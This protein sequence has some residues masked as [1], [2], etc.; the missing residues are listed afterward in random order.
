MSWLYSIVFAGLLMSSGNDASVSKNEF[1]IDNPVTV[2]SGDETEKF[3]QTYPL[4]ANGKVSVSNVNGSIVVEAW[5]RNEVRLE[6]TKIADSKEALAGVQ[7]KVESTADSLSVETDYENWK[8]NDKGD[9]NRHR[10]LEVHFKLSVPKAAVL[11]EIE[12][13]NGSV[14]L[15]NFV[16]YTKISAVNGNVTASNLRGAA[17][18]STVNGEVNADF[19]RLDTGSKISLSTV[20]GRVSLVLPSDANATIKADSLNGTITNDFGLPV[21]KGEYIGRDLHGRV[22]SGEVQIKLNSVNGGLAIGRKNDGKTPNP[23]TNLLQKGKDDGDW[24]SDTEDKA[25]LSTTRINRDISKA[26]RDAQRQTA[27]AVREARKAVATVPPAVARIKLED[28][29]NIAINIDEKA[30]S[31]QMREG[32]LKQKEALARLSE[33]NWVGSAPF[34]EK[35]SN[36]FPVKGTPKVTIDAKGCAVKVRGW[37]KPE[38][39]YVVT[40]ITGS[41][42]RIPVSVTENK[43]DS[44]V[45]LKIVNANKEDDGG[46]F[47]SDLNRVRVDVFVPRKSNLKIITNGEIRLDG[48]SG[49]IELTGADEP[50]DVRDVDGR[51]DLSAADGQVRI[52]G[53]KGDFQSRTVNGDVYL[54]GEFTR[55][56]T[57]ATDGTV[58]LT[59]PGDTNASLSSNTEI[60][61]DGLELK[62]ENTK[63]WRLGTG[64]AKYNF[65]FTEGKLVIRSS[66]MI[67]AR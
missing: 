63:N 30:I 55:L 23:A 61:T 8:W 28:L 50:I 57:R 33:A 51:L 65:D 39:K 36:S 1:Q 32:L 47:F 41:R 14:T 37:D 19:D 31:S 64:G 35:K 13:V 11:N 17:N 22:G 54:E 59:L 48:V 10:K 2:S 53:F 38:V 56:S 62:R 20:N 29:E 6:A 49:D 18:L 7:I 12:T 16:N 60:E 25:A 43:T 45:N 46:N 4:N 9:K 5:D 26:M 44:T 27:V 34:V 67:E 3:E 52:I 21:R 42:D 40:E 66:S 58:T 24:D 15:S